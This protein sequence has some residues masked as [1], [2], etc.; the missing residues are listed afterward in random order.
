MKCW[1]LGLV[2]GKCESGAEKA[3]ASVCAVLSAG[4]VT[5][6][7]DDDDAQEGQEDIPLN[8]NNN[9]YAHVRDMAVSDVM[10][11]LHRRAGELSELE[12][13]RAFGRRMTLWVRLAYSFRALCSNDWSCGTRKCRKSKSSRTR[14]RRFSRTS[15]TLAASLRSLSACC[16]SRTRRHFESSGFGSTVRSFRSLSL[17]RQTDSK[18]A[19]RRLS[20]SLFSVMLENE[21]QAE[22]QRR[23]E[24]MIAREE[25]PEKVLRLLCLATLVESGLPPKQLDMLRQ[26]MV[27]SYGVEILPSLL[28]LERVGLLQRRERGGLFAGPRASAVTVD[29]R[30]W[31]PVQPW[32][33]AALRSGL[34]AVNN[35]MQPERPTDTAYVTAGYAPLSVRLVELALLG[36]AARANLVG[37]DGQPI[38]GR[39]LGTRGWGGSE[40]LSKGPGKHFEMEQLSQ[41]IWPFQ[42]RL[43]DDGMEGGR[44]APREDEEDGRDG[45]GLPPLPKLPRWHRPRAPGSGSGTR[46]AGRGAEDGDGADMMDMERTRRRIVVVFFVG[47]A[48]YAEVAAFRFL[49]EV[50]AFLRGRKR[51]GF[52]I[53]WRSCPEFFGLHLFFC[54]PQCLS[55]SSAPRRT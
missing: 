17:P 14:Y 47:G 52:P 20:P 15:R 38:G 48:T 31:L 51:K 34:R 4:R 22:T 21:N 54:S 6:R 42:G 3:G 27:L 28:E 10:R 24:D 11:A 5:L 43:E 40:V 8:S 49:S 7:D 26:E 37:S 25:P 39:Q 9:V 29:S 32:D 53:C 41:P 19:H 18:W 45:R 35:E 30:S 46:R 55:T 23:L 44:D 36:E 16:L 33:W 13:V 1:A 2:R 12:Q 50:C